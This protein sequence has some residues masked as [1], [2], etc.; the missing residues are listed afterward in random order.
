M[1]PRARVTQESKE[2]GRPRVERAAL[3]AAAYAMAH[4]AAQRAAVGT[5]ALLPPCMPT[6]ATALGITFEHRLL[7]G[8]RSIRAQ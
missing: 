1:C 2:H 5:R 3:K 6:V 4:S 8:A 7:D